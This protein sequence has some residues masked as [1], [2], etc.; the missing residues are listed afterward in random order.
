MK[1]EILNH[2]RHVSAC[3][4][5]HDK[6]PCETYKNSRSKR[7]RSRDMAKEHRWVRRRTKQTLTVDVD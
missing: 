2:Q 4:P 3:C 7:A 5:G 1:R 6:Y